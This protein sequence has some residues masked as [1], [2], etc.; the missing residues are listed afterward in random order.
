M[1]KE[2]LLHNIRSE[3]ATLDALIAT[4]DDRASIA[5]ALEG[6]RS[7]K[8]ILAHIAAWER[9]CAGWLQAVA[10]GQTPDRPEVRDVD[11]TNARDYA[12][13]KHFSLAEVRAQSNEAHAAMIAAVE[14]LSDRDLTDEERFGWPGWQMA[15][16]N[17]D[18]H[19]REHAAE[20]ERQL[21]PRGTV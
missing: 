3:R 20:L 19:Y 4:I 9:R 12:A 18:E 6:G 7:V 10:R 8:D 21:Q 1:N 11:G 17:S 16:S 2:E 14:A 5:P 13:A 15:S